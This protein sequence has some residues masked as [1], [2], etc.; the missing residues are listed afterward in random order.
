MST[1][2]TRADTR[3]DTREQALRSLRLLDFSKK[4]QIGFRA[5]AIL[6]LADKAEQQPHSYQCTLSAGGIRHPL[7]ASLRVRVKKSTGDRDMTA[8]VVEA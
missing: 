2:L 3:R 7:L 5:K 6:S 4:I 1:C 8:L